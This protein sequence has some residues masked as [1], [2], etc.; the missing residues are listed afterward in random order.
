MATSGTFPR[1]H[2]NNIG[3]L[4]LI[5]A[6]AVICGHSPELV[7]GNRS[8]EPIDVIFH[9]LSLGTI[10]VDAFFLLSGYLI[11]KSMVDS[12][13][14]SDF[15]LRRVLRIYPAFILAWIVSF[16]GLGTMI[17]MSPF[18]M[19]VMP[20][21]HMVVL[22]GPP[23]IQTTLLHYPLLNGA[24]WTIAYEFRCY[25]LVAILG[26]TK[27][28]A[29]PK[30]V[31]LLTVLLAIVFIITSIPSVAH[32]LA[33][34][35]QTALGPG[36]V[37]VEM[38]V[39]TLP[40]T[41]RLTAIFLIGTCFYLYRSA[42]IDGMQP[43]TAGL[44]AI[45]GFAAIY[46]DPI[47]GELLLAIF[48]GASLFWL[49]YRAY[50]GRLQRIN[51]R[52]DISYGV[53]LYGWPCAT[54]LLWYWRGITPFELATISLMFA[55]IAGCISWFCLERWAKSLAARWHRSAIEAKGRVVAASA[56]SDP[57]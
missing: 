9:N 27:L 6:S 17:G 31:A 11:A 45:V 8:R 38:A 13:S 22:D 57:L 32:L 51:D 47:F 25:L 36:H 40:S 48:G 33:L 37:Y 18:R 26:M 42:L 23:P 2:K 49:S 21:L 55:L 50:L 4:R 30:A 43:I 3:L 7:D 19:G 24:M 15:L 52:W 1:A 29:R 35:W 39:G 5:F 41:I 12:K 14:L 34:E 20:L 46:R 16:Y 56:M 44:A 54:A 28:L 53:Y 10:A